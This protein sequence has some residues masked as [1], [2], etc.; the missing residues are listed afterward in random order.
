MKMSP[1]VPKRPELKRS[2]MG[3]MFGPILFSGPDSCPLHGAK[4][5]LGLGSG[6]WISCLRT[7]IHNA[8]TINYIL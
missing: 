2:G 5:N 7:W 1:N 6:L 4:R 8:T 3:P